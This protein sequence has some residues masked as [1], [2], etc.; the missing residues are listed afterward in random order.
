MNKREI[1]FVNTFF[2]GR[3]YGIPKFFKLNR[4]GMTRYTPDVYD[5]DRD[6][7]IEVVGS[8]QAYHRNKKRYKTFRECYPNVKFEIRHCT[9]ELYVES[10]KARETLQFPLLSKSDLQKIFELLKKHTKSYKASAKY[11]GLSYS[12]FCEWRWHP[13]Q[14]PAAGHRLLEFA[15]KSILH[16]EG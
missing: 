5:I 4:N 7:Y 16:P 1:Q 3:E 14:I 13:E 15:A 10:K 8:R 11:I 9:G 12:R 2:N 6:T